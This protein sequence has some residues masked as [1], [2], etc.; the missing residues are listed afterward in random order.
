MDRVHLCA[1]ID[2]ARPRSRAI[3]FRAG[4]PLAATKERRPHANCTPYVIN[5]SP[6]S[7]ANKLRLRRSY[8]PEGCPTAAGGERVCP[9][10]SKRI[11]LEWKPL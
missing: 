5:Q 10:G 2:Q 11:T 8:T 3:T 1:S 7:G 9:F 4:H 6:S